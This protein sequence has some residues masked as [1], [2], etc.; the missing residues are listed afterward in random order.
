MLAFALCLALFLY[1]L[2]VGSAVVRALHATRS[3][4]QDLLIAPA[5]GAGVVLLTVFLLNRAGLPVLAYA[6]W[7]TPALAAAAVGGHLRVTHRR[8]PAGDGISG[9][10]TLLA[11]VASGWPVLRAYLPFLAVVVLAAWLTGRPMLRWGFDW[12][13][14]CNDDMTNYCL[15]AERFLH[16]GFA[17]P[18]N[19][20]DLLAGRDWTQAYWQLHVVTMVRPGSE[21]MIAWVAATTG[22]TVHAAFMP[23]IVSF[24]LLLVSAAAGLV[25]RADDRRVPALLAALLVATSAQLTFGTLYQL[26]AQQIG[27]ALLCVNLAV[28]CRPLGGLCRRRLAHHGALVGLLVAAQLV[29]YPEVNPFL[30]AAFAVYVGVAVVRRREPWKP[31]LGVLAVGAA[32]AAVLL[33][34]YVYDAVA[35]MVNQ[36]E[37]AA[38]TGDVTTTYFP[39][40]LVPGG[41]ASVWGFVGLTAAVPE[42][43]YSWWIA[44]GAALLLVAAAVVARQAWRGEP[45]AALAL[46]F[47]VLALVLFRMRAGFGLYKLAMFAQPVVL[48]TLALAW[49]GLVN[50]RWCR[51]ATPLV[52]ALAYPGLKV[53][54][55]YVDQSQDVGSTFA[56][57]PGATSTR[58]L[59][60][61]R[62][63]VL[64]PVVDKRPPAAPPPKLMLDTYNIALSKL[65]MPYTRGIQ[66]S[67]PASAATMKILI[68]DRMAENVRPR[69]REQAVELNARMGSTMRLEPFEFVPESS[70]AARA[71]VFFFSNAGRRPTAP[72]DDPD[73]V[74]VAT[75]PRTNLLNRRHFDAG[76][77]NFVVMPLRDARNHLL[78]TTTSRSWPY[79]DTNHPDL[80]SVY[81]LERDTAFFTRDTMAGV[82]PYLLLEVLNPNEQVRLCLDLSC[83]LK[84]DGENK[85][86]RAMVVG[87]A[88]APFGFVGRGAGR[89]FSPPVRPQRINGRYYV[90]VDMGEP[91]KPFKTPRSRLSAAYGTDVSLDRRRLVGFARDVSLVGEEAYANL[92]PPSAVR[93]WKDADSDLRHPDLEYAGV[94]EDGWMAE[95][96]FLALGQP[97]GHTKLV[98]RGLVPGIG[99]P[100]FTTRLTVRVDGVPVALA[101]TSAGSP[102]RPDGRF[103]PGA[104]EVSADVPATAAGRRRVEL[105]WSDVQRLPGDDGRPAAAQLT[106]VAFEAGA[107][108]VGQ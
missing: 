62:A 104:F 67:V 2:L 16:H 103:T 78:F 92:K 15:S 35:F 33:N 25:H 36:R 26:I 95:R 100:G 17:D 52:L 29:T 31:L 93:K 86:P 77:G 70:D 44:A 101:G 48:G 108:A 81:Q 8:R 22:L 59:D 6:R 85:L 47:V 28:L 107:A 57:V 38:R 71:D 90:G 98:V 68:P 9:G 39:F 5:V 61:F 87:E 99:S 24:L 89:V 55:A 69:V 10:R 32:A 58:V 14:L 94:Y 53:Q 76:R 13:S 66:M 19:I 83:T 79:F 75:T 27:L 63:K 97:A 46:V 7:L 56:E 43:Q 74:L 73:T 84:A 34:T 40:F 65:L 64:G 106:V 80:V 50:R 20:D 23:L 21:L 102:L 45:A 60:E 37:Q 72:P 1:F 4:V 11:G 96:G 42:P 82:G 105:E 12:L 54:S 41:L 18:P 3:A 91:G 49:W 51:W 88:R 30:A